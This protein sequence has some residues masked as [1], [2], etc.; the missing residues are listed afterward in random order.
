ME[1]EQ[2]GNKPSRETFSGK[3]VR[4]FWDNSFRKEK[5]KEIFTKTR[6]MFMSSVGENIEVGPGQ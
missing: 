4:E 5:Y 1:G 6:A 2:G 3:S